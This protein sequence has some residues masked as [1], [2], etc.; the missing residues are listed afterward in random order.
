MRETELDLDFLAQSESLFTLVQ[1][2]PGLRGNLDEGE[3]RAPQRHLS[4]RL[5]RVDPAELRR[6]RLRQ[7]GGRPERGQRDRRQAHPAAGRRR[8]AGRPLRVPAPPRAPARLSRRHAD[9]LAALELGE[10][11]DGQVTHARARV[12][13]T[14]LGRGHLLRGRGRR[15]AAA[16]RHPLEPARQPARPA[17]GDDPRGGRGARQPAGEPARSRPRPAR[18][19]RAPDAAQRADD[20]GR[21]GAPARRPR[22]DGADPDRARPRPR[23]HLGRLE[24]GQ[25]LRVVKLLAYHWSSQQSVEFLRDQVDAG[26]ENA[27]AEGWDGLARTQREYLDAFWD[28]RRRRARRRPRDPAGAALRAVPRPPGRGA[29][30]GA[31]HP[32]QGPDRA[33]LR[34][35]RL[36]GHRAYVLPVLATPSPA[37][38]RGPA[39]A[40]PHPRPGAARAKELGLRGAAFPWRTIHGEECSGYWPAGTAAFH[41]NADIAGAVYRLG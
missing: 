4:Q 13:H 27:V 35:P 9:A 41:V 33:R 22:P 1:R 30:R 19:A 18:R 34:R 12:L 11:H 24:P 6:E 32:G 38:G 29:G 21:D 28:A 7:P 20:G 36:L 23:D 17:G 10:R 25:P 37:R 40:A 15:P 31:R 8:A 39:L 5:L 2:P 16:R 26:L 14:A 3:P